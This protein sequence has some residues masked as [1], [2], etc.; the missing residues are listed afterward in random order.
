MHVSALDGDLREEGEGRLLLFP[1]EGF[2][3][4]VG[5]GFLSVEIIGRECQDLETLGRVLFLE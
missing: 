5:A 2:D 4:Q 3:L 1:A